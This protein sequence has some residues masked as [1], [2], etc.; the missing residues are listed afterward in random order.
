MSPAALPRDA[1]PRATRTEQLCPH[2]P[3]SGLPWGSIEPRG[4]L[5]GP[6]CPHRARRGVLIALRKEPRLCSPVTLRVSNLGIISTLVR[7]GGHERGQSQTPGAGCLP[8]LSPCDNAH[9]DNRRTCNLADICTPTRHIPTRHMH[10]KNRCSAPQQLS[11]LQQMQC[12][13]T[14]CTHPDNRHRAPQQTQ[15][16]PT[17]TRTLT[18]DTCTPTDACA[19]RRRT[20]WAGPAWERGC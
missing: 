3:E 15:C 7:T 18:T 11:A 13:P 12:T 19:P 1:L 2:C 20:S 9:P 14:K 10:P 8:T 6:P 16:T 4:P 5:L 17:D